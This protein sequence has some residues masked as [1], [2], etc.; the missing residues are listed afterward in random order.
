MLVT[1]T[2]QTGPDSEPFTREIEAGASLQDLYNEHRSRLPY[3]IIAVLVNNKEEDFTYIIERPCNIRFLDMR[4]NLADRVYQRSLCLLYLKAVYDTIRHADV[5][6]LNSLNRGLYTEIHAPEP[7]TD[8]QITNIEKR[9]WE[10]VDENL[11]ISKTVISRDDLIKYLGNI[12]SSEKIELLENTPDVH[13]IAVCE[14][15]G[16]R[17]YFYGH[18][19][20]ST[21][22]L[23]HFELHRFRS[24]ILVRYPHPS[25][26]D[27]LPP[28][29]DDNNI[30]DAFEEGWEIGQLFD[31]SYAGD[32]NRE[33]AKGKAAEIIALSERLHSAKISKIARM[34][35]DR[36][37]RIILIAGPSSSGKTTFSKRLIAELA[38]LE[39]PAL[40]IGTDDYFID[41]NKTPL[42]E[43]GE[44]NFEG[45][46]A[47]DV[48]AFDTDINALLSGETVDIPIY[49]FIEGTR[50][51][52]VRKESL[53]ADHLIVIEG[54]HALNRHLTEHIAEDEKFR[55]YISPLTQ[56]N[57]DDHNRI[58]TTDVR[59]I[60]RMIRDGRT[61]GNSV[62][63]TI[64]SWPKVRR[65][66]D[67]NIF[68]YNSEADIVFNSAL[69]YELAVLRRHAENLLDQVG[70]D[71][72][73]YGDATRLLDFLRF[74]KPIEDESA[75]P[76]NSILREFIGGGLV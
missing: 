17:N 34:I 66:E 44:H 32:L 71:E 16:Y 47:I 36:K 56:L 57:L 31:L 8:A 28:Y 38:S 39:I 4:S 20:P 13:Y 33:T 61:R 11:P 51:Y 12:V 64:K 67:V 58:P 70:P 15:G 24:G 48:D 55:I 72:A 35:K 43:K 73:E 69:I 3:R 23:R 50:K 37:K 25:Y 53:E 7:V 22:F 5:K 21:G 63:Q 9:M 2:L 19:A 59:L 46:D 76:E 30:F 68:P 75:I 6:I 26:P 27:Q 60:R 14:L 54:I 41:R 29:V 42:D 52:G 45:L 40:Y 1:I 74:F 49:D 62:V 10:L 18:V 65:G